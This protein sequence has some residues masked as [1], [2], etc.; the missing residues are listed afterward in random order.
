[1]AIAD[2]VALPQ[3]LYNIRGR[4]AVNI[5]SEVTARL[6]K[7]PNIVGVKEACG[8]LDQISRTIELC[9]PQFT[10]LSGDDSLT[11]P[12]VSVGGRG[13]I[14]VTANI[15]PREVVALIKAALG[16]DFA[17]C[18]RAALQARSAEPRALRRGQP[19]RHQG[20]AGHGW[21]L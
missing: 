4:S 8:S 7:H 18:P 1:M 13:L 20:G 12:I 21:L 11:L 14:G 16:G 19:P 15:A 17:T 6:A 9:G 2:A 3:L 10:V 5:S